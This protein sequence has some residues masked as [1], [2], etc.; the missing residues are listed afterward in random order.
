MRGRRTICFSKLNAK[1]GNA[2]GNTSTYTNNSEK[3]TARTLLASFPAPN[4]LFREMYK[5]TLKC[6]HTELYNV[7]MQGA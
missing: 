1:D 7:C 5:K 2:P 4:P 3:N 6:P